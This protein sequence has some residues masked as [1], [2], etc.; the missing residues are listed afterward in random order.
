MQ[1]ICANDRASTSF[2]YTSSGQKFRGTFSALGAP[3]PFHPATGSVS[4]S[5]TVFFSLPMRNHR[6]SAWR[7]KNFHLITINVLRC[8]L[9]V[10]LLCTIGIRTKVTTINVVLEILCYRQRNIYDRNISVKSGRTTLRS[11]T[12]FAS[13][14]FPEVPFR[15]A[16]VIQQSHTSNLSCLEERYKGGHLSVREGIIRPFTRQQRIGVRGEGPMGRILAGVTIN[17]FFYWIAINNNCRARVRL[18]EFHISGLRRFANFRGAR[19]LNLG[20]RHRL[21]SLIRRSHTIIYFLGRSFHLFRY[22]NRD[23]HLV[24]RR[25]T[26]RRVTAREKT[27]SDSGNFVATKAIL[28][29][30]LYGRFFTDPNLSNRRSKGVHNNGLTYREGDLLCDEQATSSDNGQVLF[31]CDLLLTMNGND[32]FR[33]LYGRKGSFVIIIA[34]NSVIGHAILSDLCSIKSVA[35]NHGRSRFQGKARTFRFESGLRAT[36]I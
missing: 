7:T 29:S 4:R 15:S 10:R 3:T 16:S 11:V 21:A 24:P 22:A 20:V 5:G 17:G 27:I 25:L 6:T 8:L 34:F 1:L 14:P 2:R 32:L 26:F 18:S 36:P 33:H 28:I 35:I 31:T 19:W 12:R 13:V 30:K 23:S 9:G